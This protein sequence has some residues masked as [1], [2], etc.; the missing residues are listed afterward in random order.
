VGCAM[1]VEVSS[2]TRPDAAEIVAQVALAKRDLLLH[3]Y[4]R[5]LRWED[6]E[7]C[8]SQATLELVARAR[9]GAGFESRQ[10]VSNALEQKFVS[11]IN[12]RHRAAGGRSSTE[13]ALSAAIS[14][15]DDSSGVADLADH[16]A[17]VA[18]HV[19]IRQE[20]RR[21]REVAEDLT[22]DQRLVL[23]SQVSLGM[24]SAEFCRRH[25]WSA[26][27]FRK[28]AQRA[29]AK[30]RVLVIDYQSG[31]RCRQLE[32]A[33]MALASG[34]ADEQERERA[35]L[36]ISN[37]ATCAQMI[38][39]LA[40]AEREIAGVLSPLP[41]GVGGLVAKLTT[42]LAGPG[43]RLARLA[44][45]PHA[46]TTAAGTGAAASGGA[47]LGAGSSVFGLGAIKLG[48][49]ALCVAGVAGGYAV[50][51]RTGL[52]F[53][54]GAAHTKSAGASRR[55]G[56]GSAP[57]ASLRPPVTYFT[58]PV[59]GSGGGNTGQRQASRVSP[60]SVA[61]GGTADRQARQEFGG[62]SRGSRGTQ[63]VS[64]QPASTTSGGPAARPSSNFETQVAAAQRGS[65]P[66]G[67]AG[68]GAT[69]E[70]GAGG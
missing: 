68:A 20:L 15:E 69:S 65:S 14:V 11:R 51:A 58:A 56:R 62:S 37:C 39:G 8:Y 19:I 70:F 27:K 61:R 60:P 31:E 3:V 35:E 2:T 21:I 28:V 45:G 5:R 12:D 7:D 13:A 36:H 44:P 18:D 53:H 33:L 42:L 32:P 48:A 25:G 46:T 24:G 9:R 22:P 54:D 59:R 34:A 38:R 23:A 6:L 1:A 10:H 30:L 57:T 43:R 47:A 66:P 29:R 64:F 41:I 50:C 63:S 49:A 52:L 16:R 26:E 17:Q 4:R 40:R 55:L 67:R